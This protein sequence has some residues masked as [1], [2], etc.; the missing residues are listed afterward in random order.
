MPDSL[1]IRVLL[2]DDE[3]LVRAGLA[4]LVETEPDLT[5]VG[6]AGDGGQALEIAAATRPDVV[7]MDV[8]MPRVD[9][10]EATRRIV[11]DEFMSGSD[12]STAVLVLTTFNDD[13]A[14]FDALRAGA[15]GFML[16]NAAPGTLADAVRAVAAGDA[17][18]DPAVARR[19]LGEFA[20]RPDPMLP[21]PA[22]LRRLTIR[23][24]E[25][26]VLAAHGLTNAAIADH[27]VISEAT[28][29]T[30]IARV[31]TK[32]GL[33]DRTQAVVAAYKCGLVRPGDPP[34]PG[35]GAQTHGGHRSS[36]GTSA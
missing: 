31:L 25:V 24:T 33:H 20:A 9:G 6:E 16:K 36:R 29:K 14:V 23:E 5:V 22:E 7:V 21:A 32:L 1:Q 15:S 11:S 10:V 27:L 34:P 3:P 12:F 35:P 18:L 8:R 28:V 13:R 2:V 30:H 17:W 26:L 4:M 19:L